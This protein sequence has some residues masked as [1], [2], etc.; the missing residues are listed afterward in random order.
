MADKVSAL[1]VIT[2][3][4][5]LGTDDIVLNHAGQTST[6]SADNFSTWLATAGVSLPA[7][8]TVGSAAAYLENNAVFNVKDYGAVGD[9]AS[10]PLSASFATLAAA[11]AV[12]P[13]ATSLTNELDWAAI[14]LAVNAAQAAFD[15]GV[16]TGAAVYFPSGVYLVNR[17]VQ[18]AVG[19]GIR[20]YGEGITQTAVTT[21]A[22]ISATLTLGTTLAQ[23]GDMD[24]ANMTWDGGVLRPG[25]GSPLADY[26]IYGSRVD[27]SRFDRVR[28]SG[29]AVTGCSIG[30][31]YT[32]TFRECRWS[33]NTGDGFATNNDAGLGQSNNSV[34]FIACLALNNDG[35]GYRLRAGYGNRFFGGNI[36]QC[37][38]GGIFI[39][40]QINGLV[41]HGVYFEGNCVT[42]YSL[43]ALTVRGHIILNGSTV[44]T[45]MD[46]AAPSQGVSIAGCFVS[47]HG[48]TNE[49]FVYAIAVDGLVLQGNQGTPSSGSAI[50][51]ITAYVNPTLGSVA[52]ATI[53]S[54]QGFSATDEITLVSL[55]SAAET[56]F[57]R[58][59]SSNVVQQNYAETDLMRWILIA[60][61]AAAGFR[62]SSSTFRAQPVWE[63][64][65]TAGGSASNLFGFSL[66]MSLYPQ[67]QAKVVVL[68][69]WVSQTDVTN[70][71]ALY[72]QGNSSASGAVANAG[73]RFVEVAALL[74]SSGTVNF[75]FYDLTPTNAKV[76]KITEPV[77]ALVG[78]AH[79]ELVSVGPH[80]RVWWGTA[81]PTTGTWVVGDRV[82]NRTPAVASPKGWLCTVAGTPGT[83]VTE[84]NL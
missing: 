59:K 81:A 43:S 33:N 55:P 42:G 49:T 12:Y 40:R 22:A 64:N 77:L 9:Y 44:E 1:P 50:P 27:N 73:W 7:G 47:S 79:D 30:Y 45:T 66:D 62:R 82:Q 23:L 6:V 80:Q 16:T 32:N 38:K 84:G 56:K 35:F 36:E 53:V 48:Y 57:R 8:R 21:N 68:S 20:M 78:A 31:G 5:I 58:W 13:H 29:A 17:T 69:A 52:H 65:E 24:I 4:D 51:L 39:T 19:H 60:G 54:N 14:Q 10:H 72:C 74:P 75:G 46:Y 41:I 28:A 37:G 34:D 71:A 70:G 15:A 61:G 83:W 67:L 63:I 3:A 76:V 26:A 11:Q 2:S 18:V 25:G